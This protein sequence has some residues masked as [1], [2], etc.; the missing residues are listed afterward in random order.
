MI[1]PEV[2]KHVVNKT[3]MEKVPDIDEKIFYFQGCT[4]KG[5]PGINNAFIEIMKIMGNEPF[6]SDEQSCC[7]GNF[8]PFNTSPLVTTAAITQRNYNVIKKYSTSC[9]TSCNGCFSSF[10]NTNGYLE[11]DAN[12]KKEV[13]NVL[14][15]IGKEYI[16]DVEVIHAAEFFYKNRHVLKN[17]MKHSLSGI[18][19]AVHYGCH[20]LHV[21][22]YSTMIDDV[23]RPIILEETLKELKAD[24]ADYEEYQ[25]CCGAGLNQRIIQED[26]TNSLKIT[27]RKLNSIM[28]HEPDALIVIC[29][30]CQF[31][32]DN[33][34]FELEVEFDEEFELPVIHLNELLGI[35]MDLPANVL[36][37]DSHKVPLDD[38]LEKV[39]Y[40]G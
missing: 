19:L 26:R 38:F 12:L 24:I 9:I 27:L 1:E 6:T 17:Y 14:Q 34:Q 36:R 28:K 3:R 5:Y 23:E 21:E 33:A 37:L 31:H 8:L 4:E 30:Y 29:P 22:D 11:K 18:K 13:K 20:F 25:L 32:L 40:N 39:G 35:L 7:T 15:Q 10:H 16:E 2:K